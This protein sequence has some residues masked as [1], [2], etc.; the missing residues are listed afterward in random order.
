MPA[1]TGP[2][3]WF[4]AAAVMTG[5]VFYGMLFGYGSRWM[6]GLSVIAFMF[7]AGHSTL[8][9]KK[10]YGEGVRDCV[11]EG[12]KIYLLRMKD[13]VEARERS[14]RVTAELMGI[15]EEQRWSAVAG[16]IMLYAEPDSLLLNGRPGSY[17]LVY[18]N[19][20]TLKNPQNPAEFDYGKYLSR[21]GIF[22]TVFIKKEKYLLIREGPEKSIME[23]AAGVRR[24]LLDKL[25]DHGIRGRNFGLSSAL[26]LGDDTNIDADIRDIYARAG[27]M[28][29]LCVSGLHVGVVFLVLGFILRFLKHSRPGRT[30][31]P[32]L[33]MLGVW[34]YAL[35]TGLAPPVVRASCMISFF[36]IGDSFKRHKNS[37]NTLAAS[38]L[39][40]LLIDPELIFSAG[41]QLSYSAVLGIL[42]LQRPIYNLL[43]MKYL[44]LDRIWSITAVSIAAQAGTLAVVLYY[45]HRFPLYSLITNLIV[46]PLSS[47]IIY[48]GMLL[49]ILPSQTTAAQASS[50]LLDMLVTIMDRGVEFVEHIPYGMMENLYFDLNM[51]IL[52]AIIIGLLA[53]TFNE[54]QKGALI[55]AL[56]VVLAFS[57]YRLN[58]SFKTLHQQEFIVYSIHGHSAY[59]VIQGE[60]HTFYADSLLLASPGKIDYSIAPN[61]LS[62]NLKEP[63][64]QRLNAKYFTLNTK[65]KR[66]LIWD[67]KAPGVSVATS[68][69]LDYLILRGNTEMDLLELFDYFNPGLVI[70]DSS[71]PPWI[72][73][74]EGDERFYDVRKSGAYISSECRVP[75]A[76]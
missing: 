47:L 42:L 19:M 18:A 65:R 69:S 20:D 62:L 46:I 4:I 23:I 22:H 41:F 67:G 8:E 32:L 48:S 49:F 21:K 6:Y 58:L 37:F 66:V 57:A 75:G 2:A 24:D 25:E 51:S 54:K 28:H 12:E 68:L 72:E 10:E 43:Y 45:F 11:P 53:Y 36:I 55:F 76:E 9:Q 74:P 63:C 44:L 38:A 13:H 61:W 17:L 64:T 7:I 27:A 39:L 70:I 60:E 40:M 30:M 73:A 29:I 26:L 3:L 5:G 50:W 34:S 59:D 33:L 71:V 16:E 31:L 35:I 15:R 56:L 14:Y 52:L 1:E